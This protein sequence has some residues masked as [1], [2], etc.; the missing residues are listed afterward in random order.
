MFVIIIISIYLC[1][2]LSFTEEGLNEEPEPKP[3]ELPKWF[4][5]QRRKIVNEEGSRRFSVDEEIAEKQREAKR[6]KKAE[7]KLRAMREREPKED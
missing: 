5:V 3:F 1:Q 2:S 4:P 7:E 6:V